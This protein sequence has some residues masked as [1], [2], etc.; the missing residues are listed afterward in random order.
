M[1]S[2]IGLRLILGACLWITVALV[3]TAFLL[4]GMFRGYAEQT[5]LSEL[6]DHAEELVELSGIDKRGAVYLVRHPIDP[7]FNRP[8]S[9][10]YW[11]VLIDGAKEERS[12]SLDGLDFPVPAGQIDKAGMMYSVASPGMEPLQVFAQNLESSKSAVS[13]LILVAGPTAAIEKLVHSFNKTLAASLA[14]LG[15]GLVGAVA[16]Q[17][18]FGLQP[19]R[20]ISRTISEIRAGRADR[21]DGQFP[22]EIKP[23][24]HELNA[25]LDHNT[26]V[27]E[28]AR[29]QT[30]NLAHTLKTPL[31]VLT[32]E[33]EQPNGGNNEVVQQQIAL[34]A[35][36]IDRNL[37]R[38]RAAGARGILGARAEVDSVVA[39]LRRTLEHLYKERGIAI[40]VEGTDSLVFRGERQDLEEILGNLI[41]NAC[42]WA[43]TEV[44]VR[45]ERVDETVRLTIEDDGQ[46]IKEEQLEE[47]LKRGRKL[48]ETSPGS[49]LGLHIVHDLVELY[50]GS[51]ILTRS[52]LGGLLV[53]LEIPSA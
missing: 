33:A 51:L 53:T 11:K 8:R 38:A 43:R 10:W 14:L 52:S 22:S 46:G 45:A 27:I 36:S 41:D 5:M 25:L 31:A 7:R 49:G 40:I 34:M 44:R 28:R 30:G 6:R 32:N 26:A 35:H 2:S 39:G 42:K 16:L 37:S 3:A 50:S 18:M 1:R 12:A 48:D 13:A 20:Q 24:A 4:T 19:L 23:L 17:V 15:L 9:G 21:L 29:V 47:V